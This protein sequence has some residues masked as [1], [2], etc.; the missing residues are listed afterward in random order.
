MQILR[1]AL[2][3][4]SAVEVENASDQHLYVIDITTVEMGLIKSTAVSNITYVYVVTYVIQ[5][6]VYV[7][8]YV[9]KIHLVYVVATCVSVSFTVS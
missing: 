5:H 7:C 4:S 2:T 8:M 1:F 3:I 9:H 6:Q